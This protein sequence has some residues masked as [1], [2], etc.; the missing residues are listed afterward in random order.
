MKRSRKELKREGLAAGDSHGAAAHA[1]QILDLRLHA[2]DF[3]VLAAQVVDEN[4]ARSGEP[5]PARPAVEKRRTKLLFQ[6]EDTLADRGLRNAQAAGRFAVVQMMS[7][8]DEV[9][10]RA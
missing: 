3:A 4:F 1:L 6:V 2:F 5:H 10:Q 9:A 7:D 8:A